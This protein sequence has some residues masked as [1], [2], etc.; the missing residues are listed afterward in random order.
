[1]QQDLFFFPDQEQISKELSVANIRLSILT[2]WQYANSKK[3]G[4]KIAM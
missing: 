2:L 3:V 4:G 1:M